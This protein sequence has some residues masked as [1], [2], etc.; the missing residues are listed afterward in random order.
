MSGIVDNI[1]EMSVINGI[2]KNIKSALSDV[3]VN[4]DN[5]DIT[6]V[7]DI[8]RANLVSNSING[9][10][11]IAGDG[12]KIT[13]TVDNDNNVVYTISTCMD[14]FPLNRPDYANE[15]LLFGN[16]MSLPDIINDIFN[17]ILPNIKGVHYADTT[18]SNDDGRDVTNWVNTYFDVSGIKRGLLPNTKYIRLY[19]TSQHEPLYIEI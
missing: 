9:I 5:V 16:T 6:H 4:T 12:I 1:T 2:E 19:L 14:T 13:P 11:F 7:P 17:N 15:N 8:I 3:G 10:K 18:R